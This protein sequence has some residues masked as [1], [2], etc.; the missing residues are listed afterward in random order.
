MIIL[1]FAQNIAGTCQTR[2]VDAVVLST[3][4]LSFGRKTIGNRLHTPVL[5]YIKVG[6]KGVYILH[7]NIIPLFTHIS[8]AKNVKPCLRYVFLELFRSNLI[9][10]PPHEK[11]NNLHMRKQ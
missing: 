9:N 3:H 11:T 2:I 8:S 7:G 4:N 6:K 1:A 5:L 10:E